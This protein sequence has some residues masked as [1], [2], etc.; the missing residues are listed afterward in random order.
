MNSPMKDTQRLILSGHLRHNG[1]PVLRWCVANL[2]P[3]RDAAENIKPGKTRSKERIDGAVAMIMAVGRA[4]LGDHGGSIYDDED[5]R[6]DG[7]LVL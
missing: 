5:A 1:H 7:L 2:V 3:E 6:P 4:C